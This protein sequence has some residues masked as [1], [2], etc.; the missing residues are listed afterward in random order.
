MHVYMPTFP[1]PVNV[2]SDPTNHCWP[3]YRPVGVITTLG[4]HQ[5]GVAT[6][7]AP[8]LCPPDVHSAL[9][10]CPPDVPACCALLPCTPAVHLWHALLLCPPDAPPCCCEH[11]LC[12]PSV[13]SCCRSPPIV[14]SWRAYSYCALLLRPLLLCSH[15]TVHDT[16]ECLGVGGEHVAAQAQRMQPCVSEKQGV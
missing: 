16:G 10:P 14:P 3:R 2:R 7:C 15:V 11:L 4:L 1:L 8:L 6:F 12:P 9:L 13:H 5:L